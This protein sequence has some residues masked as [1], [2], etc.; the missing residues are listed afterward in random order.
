MLNKSD[1]LADF[2]ENAAELRKITSTI[3]LVKNDKDVSITNIDIHG[4]AS[5][6]GPYDNNVRLANNRAAALR[7][8]VCNLYTIDKKLFTYHATPEDWEGFKKKVEASHLA[9]KSAILAVANSSLAPDAKDQKIKKL[10][11]ASYRYIMSEIYP[12][13]RH[14][15]LIDF[16]S[17]GY[18]QLH[19]GRQLL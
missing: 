5:P 14:S 6:D 19:H 9:D 2:R 7:N 3:D 4:Y 11:P 12:R 15:R 13:L 18:Q 10:Y 17:L 1:I 16:R 8:Y